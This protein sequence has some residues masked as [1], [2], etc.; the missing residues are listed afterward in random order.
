MMA[1]EIEGTV[2]SEIRRFHAGSFDQHAALEA[3]DAAIKDA[4]AAQGALGRHIGWLQDV[5]RQRKIEVEK[6]EW[7]RG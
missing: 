3:I 1:G 7:P 5:K 6:G 2:K 4:D